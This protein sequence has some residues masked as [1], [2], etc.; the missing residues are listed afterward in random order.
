MT[1]LTVGGVLYCDGKCQWPIE[2]VAEDNEPRRAVLEARRE[3]ADLT[4]HRFDMH[5]YGDRL[6]C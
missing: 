2:W 4:S 1:H 6:A 3:L 5:L